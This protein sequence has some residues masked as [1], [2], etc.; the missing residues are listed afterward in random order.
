MYFIHLHGNV[1]AKTGK[2]AV[3]KIVEEHCIESKL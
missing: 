1:L 2:S 3:F